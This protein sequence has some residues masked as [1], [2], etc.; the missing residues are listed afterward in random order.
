MARTPNLTRA[1]PARQQMDRSNDPE[2]TRAMDAAAPEAAMSS[3]RQRF[4]GAAAGVGS[5]GFRESGA[6]DVGAGS[7]E[8]VSSPDPTPDP[9]PA[10][11]PSPGAA[12]LRR[13]SGH[14]H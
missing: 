14:G 8:G 12:D 3:R 13:R 11:G 9:A 7:R 5:V 6:F 10:T 4:A 2:E 1:A